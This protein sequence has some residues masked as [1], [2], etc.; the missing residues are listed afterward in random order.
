MENNQTI[1]FLRSKTISVSFK[2]Q[3]NYDIKQDNFVKLHI[4][5]VGGVCVCVWLQK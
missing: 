1:F 4:I 2:D 5:C 3:V